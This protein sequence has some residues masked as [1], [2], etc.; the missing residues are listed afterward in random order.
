MPAATASKAKRSY[1]RS[2][3]YM[4]DPLIDDAEGALPPLEAHA[5]IEEKEPA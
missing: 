1:P 2:A 3:D 5:A 4:P